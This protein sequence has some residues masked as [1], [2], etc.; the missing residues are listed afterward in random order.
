MTVVKVTAAADSKV[1]SVPYCVTI[2][3]N[4]DHH[5]LA[6]V[7]SDVPYRNLDVG[8]EKIALAPITA[9]CATAELV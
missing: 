3:S 1:V 5:H 4:P 7:A 2:E 9:M 6:A 8:Q